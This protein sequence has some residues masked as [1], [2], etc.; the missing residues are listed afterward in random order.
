MKR[1]DKTPKTQ[2]NKKPLKIDKKLFSLPVR[3]KLKKAFNKVS[4]AFTVSLVISAIGACCLAFLF[5]DFY[6]VQHENSYLQMEIRKNLQMVDKN[7][8]WASTSSSAIET[9]QKLTN[10]VNYSDILTRQVSKLINNFDE[11]ELTGP[12]STAMM[13]FID[14]R[15]QIQKY[16]NADDKEAAFALYEAEYSD[17]VTDMENA[18]IAIGDRTDELASAEYFITS[19]IALIVLILTIT[20]IVSSI[21]LS[22]NLTKQITHVI[23]EPLKELEAAATKLKDGELDIEIVYESSDELG[24]LAKNFRAACAQMKDVIQ[25]AGYVLS[26]MAN[27]DFTVQTKA[28]AL[29][30]GNFRALL[31]NMIILSEQMSATLGQIKDASEQVSVGSSQLANSAQSL[32]E[33]A[34]DQAGAVQELTATVT[35]VSEIAA[36][37]SEMATM[38]AANMADAAKDGEASRQEMVNLTHAMESIMNTS[39][40]IENIISMIE[41]IAEQT[42]LLSLNASIEAARA[43][44]AGRGFAVVADQIGKLAADSGKSAVM[45]K[46]LINK[47]LEEIN[48]GNEIVQNASE[49]MEK[50]LESMAVFA[51][52]ASGAATA[53]TTQADMLKQVEAGIEQISQVVQD[54]SAVAEETSAVS[55]EL[56]AQAENLQ[57]MIGQF[58]LQ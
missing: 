5:N 18:L 23:C 22:G 54:N 40:E 25:D 42:N 45:T 47:S 14:Q 13:N 32:A 7:V 20:G 53:T 43:G 6:T 44:E 49:M 39:H 56:F 27:K 41:D 31:E 12:L 17:A 57:E 37:T 21:L 2:K 34:T 36:K 4:I 1:K 38:S 46:D 55:E 10:V 52:E 48:H 16:I 15:S 33:G 9:S 50:V 24:H 58:T 11:P 30:V 19:I 26:T 29:Y 3:D 8:L 35:S 28:E 51:Q